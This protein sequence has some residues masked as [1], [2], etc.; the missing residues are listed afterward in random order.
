MLEILD[1]V[2]ES[3]LMVL[4]VSFKITMLC[5]KKVKNKSLDNSGNAVKHIKRDEDEDITLNKYLFQKENE[6][7]KQGLDKHEIDDKLQVDTK[8]WEKKH[9]SWHDSK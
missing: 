9:G 5:D 6:Y 7:K 4:F 2:K 1:F 8:I 3:M